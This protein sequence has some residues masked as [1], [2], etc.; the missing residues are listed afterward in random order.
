MRKTWV[1]AI[2][3]AT[4]L[5]VAMV[6]VRSARGRKVPESPGGSA[7]VVNTAVSAKTIA[8]QKREGCAPVAG[9]GF[10]CGA[11]REDTDCPEKS[12]CI[13]NLATG[14]TECQAPDCSKSQECEKG[15]YCRVVARTPSGV[16]VQACVAP[17]ARPAGAACDPDNASDPSVSCAGNMVCIDGGC[18]PPCEPTPIKEDSEECGYLGCIGTDNG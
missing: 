4:L 6:F 3:M 5:V 14:R 18:S 7:F 11:C 1:A 10:S 16:A 15:T 17:G 13:V 12:A 9:G 8:R 2:V